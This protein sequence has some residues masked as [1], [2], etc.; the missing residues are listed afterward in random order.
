[1]CV[2]IFL[3]I[4]NHHESENKESYNFIDQNLLSVSEFVPIFILFLSGGKTSVCYSN[5]NHLDKH[6]NLNK[7][8]ALYFL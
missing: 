5:L 1:M 2:S 3:S 8:A 4:L 7:N 6:L